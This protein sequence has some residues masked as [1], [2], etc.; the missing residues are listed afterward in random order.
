VG[1]HGADVTIILGWDAHN[2]NSAGVAVA[3]KLGEPV[4]EGVGSSFGA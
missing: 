1:F 4:G 3:P 2:S